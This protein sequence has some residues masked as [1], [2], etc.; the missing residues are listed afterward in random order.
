MVCGENEIVQATVNGF[1]KLFI[2]NKKLLLA[3][4]VLE[5]SVADR[6][7]AFSNAWLAEH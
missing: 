5:S 2:G 4:N 6:R 1:Q 7:G 3:A